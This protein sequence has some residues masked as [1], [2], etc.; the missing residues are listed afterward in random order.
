[1][2]SMRMWSINGAGELS[3]AKT[4]LWKDCILR[5]WFGLGMYPALMSAGA[6]VG[7]TVKSRVQ[8]RFRD[9]HGCFRWSAWAFTHYNRWDNDKRL[10]DFC[11]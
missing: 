4:R 1:L 10:R 11:I 8:E 6:E 5:E 9:E 7:F 2:T 3:F